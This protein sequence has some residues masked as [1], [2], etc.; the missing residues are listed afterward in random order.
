[1]KARFFLSL[2]CFVF[3]SFF[4]SCESPEEA[5]AAKYFIK[6]K[7]NGEFKFYQVSEPGYQSC[8]QCACSYL[9]PSAD[10]SSNI[11]VCNEDNDWVTGAHIESWNGSTI[12]FTGLG[13]P[14][15]SFEYTEGG[16]TYLS[17]LA[18]SQVGSTVSITSVTTDG[19]YLDTY[20]QYKVKGTFRCNVR[21]NGGVS[22][23]AI[24]E[25]SFIV[26]YSED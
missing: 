18:S 16:V 12:E 5:G 23:I 3:I 6:F 9:P 11:S 1:M 26:R 22:D 7:A 10:N 4:F 2:S 21:S 8:G 17:E 25:G 20:Q 19:A 14:L 15:A 13:F 24:T